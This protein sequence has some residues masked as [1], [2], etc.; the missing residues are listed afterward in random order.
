[1][2]RQGVG[3]PHFHSTFGTRDAGNTY[4]SEVVIARSGNYRGEIHIIV[5]HFANLCTR[6][7]CH[8]RC[9]GDEL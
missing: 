4:Q 8:V 3:G 1:M 6:S 2:T 9:M 7:R 5:S